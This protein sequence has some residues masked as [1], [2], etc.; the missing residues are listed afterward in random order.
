MKDWSVYYSAL[1]NNFVLPAHRCLVVE[2]G[3]G[4][5]SGPYNRGMM[6]V[7]THFLG[8]ILM[9]RSY[10]PDGGRVRFNLFHIT[11]IGMKILQKLK[12]SGE[13]DDFVS[14]NFGKLEN[15]FCLFQIL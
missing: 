9:G 11:P 10:S 6:S 4:W 2:T 7:L 14:K 3:Q 15:C 1:G 8:R 5:H 13:A 12:A